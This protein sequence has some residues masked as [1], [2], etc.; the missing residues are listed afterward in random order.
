MDWQ[1]W[2]GAIELPLLIFGF[3]VLGKLLSQHR[4]EVRQDLETQGKRIYQAKDAVASLGLRMAT[5]Y[6][7]KDALSDFRREMADFRRE[8]V[9]HL[10]LIE[11]RLPLRPGGD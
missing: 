9:E 7:T 1:W 3:G 6:V 10:R 4:A 11:S 2:A 8:F 5:D